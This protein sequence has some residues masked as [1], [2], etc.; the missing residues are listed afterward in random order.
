[1]SPQLKH[2]YEFGPFRLDAGERV[3]L[4]GGHPVPL[5][6][7]AL[8]ILVVL[9]QRGGRVIS[10]DELM[11]AVWPHTFVEEGN[12]AFQI[13]QLRKALGSMEAPNAFIETVPRRGY[14]LVPEVREVK[15]GAPEIVVAPSRTVEEAEGEAG[16]A[17]AGLV[18]AARRWPAF[19]RLPRFFFTRNA[20]LAAAVLVPLTLWLYFARRDPPEPPMRL[21]PGTD[22]PGT[23][24]QP[25]FSPD[26]SHLAFVWREEDDRNPDLYLK[27]V[28]SSTLLRLTS[29]PR[30]EQNPVWSPDGRRI[31][32]LR[33]FPHGAEL[34]VIPALG[35]PERRLA[36]F[37]GT[38]GSLDWSPAGGLLALTFR[39]H[40]AEPFAIFLFDLATLKSR[41]LIAPPPGSIGDAHLAFSPDGRMLAFSRHSPGGIGIYVVPVKGGKPRQVA[42]MFGYHL[43]WTADGREIV[44]STDDQPARHTLWRVP[45]SGGPPV[46]LGVAEGDAV[47]FSISRQ[48][49]LLAY[50]SRTQVINIWR[51]AL[52]SSGNDPPAPFIASTFVDSHP[53]YSPDG[54]QIAFKSTRSG[55]S[56]IWI[57]D[58]DGRNPARLPFLGGPTEGDARW[59]PDG[60]QLVF[61]AR[62]ETR[63]AIFLMDARGGVSRR[64]PVED[65][66]QVSPAWSRDGNWVYYSSN[67]TGRWEIWKVPARGGAPVQVTRRGGG[68]AAYESADGRTLF[69]TKR[70]EPGIW[71]MPLPAGE[72]SLVVEGF[73]PAHWGYWTVTPR[74]LYL[75]KE[76]GS[77][78]QWTIEHL[79]LASRRR[80][81]I[82]R[83]DKRVPW[84]GPGLDVSPDGRWLLI[85]LVDQRSSDIMLVENFR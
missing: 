61:G 47:T 57:C 64:L 56:E 80:R 79:D 29:H 59:S 69:Y 33:S 73:D 22:L 27:V 51:F 13:F 17:G 24:S 6:P 34:L 11:R 58:A 77:V 8:E 85:N 66:D 39:K 81:T 83:I 20:L 30:E 75:A 63:R 3:L 23:E 4:R 36:D 1:M 67:R 70:H 7:K 16:E 35:G 28:D 14:R 52:I 18:P 78:T 25:A 38:V 53:Q 76:Q 15:D 21:V 42:S 49:N 45:V 19:P 37:P 55:S 54:Q 48:G 82:L 68:F 46:R 12:L 5:T 32:F 41:K 26:G 40:R 10:K 60:R 74:G 84:E 2:F 50:S 31:A 65:A 72:E 9:V 43:D 44:F 71:R 62:V